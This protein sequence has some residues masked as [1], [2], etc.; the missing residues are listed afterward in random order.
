MTVL[1]LSPSLFHHSP[2]RRLRRPD[3]ARHIGAQHRQAH[4]HPMPQHCPP[5]RL[6]VV[7]DPRQQP[8]PGSA[9][10]SGKEKQSWVEK[11][12][13]VEAPQSQRRGRLCVC[14][15]V[16]PFIQ[17]VCVM[18]SCMH[19]C[20]TYVQLAYTHI[21]P[22]RPSPPVRPLHLPRQRHPSPSKIP[23]RPA[24]TAATKRDNTTWLHHPA[25]AAAA[26][27]LLNDRLRPHQPPAPVPVPLL[28]QRRPPLSRGPPR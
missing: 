18:N 21:P 17:Y 2:P 4:L 28:P 20:V 26:G 5:Q 19:P 10:P 22:P 16:R 23:L 24:T 13:K 15:C 1:Y 8:R 11:P 7:L 3:H 27:G 6:E 9:H 14:V 25:P 12:A